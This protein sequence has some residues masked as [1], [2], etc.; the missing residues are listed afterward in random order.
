MFAKISSKIRSL[1]NRMLARQGDYKPSGAPGLWMANR[2]VPF[3]TLEWIERMRLDHQV[4]LCLAA[5]KGPL[6]SAKINVTSKDQ[7]VQKLVETT[8]RRFWEFSL[9]Q[10]TEAV[11][12][13]ISGGELVYR[14]SDD[15][16]AYD[17]LIDFYVSDI[18]PLKSGRNFAGVRADGV[19]GGSGDF[20]GAKAW[21]H[22]HRPAHGGFYGQSR[23]RGAFD[24]WYEKRMDGGAIDVRKLWFHKNAFWGGEIRFPDGNSVDENGRVVLNRDIARQIMELYRTGGIV[25]LPSTM[26]LNGG[27]YQW[28]IEKP[29]FNGNAGDILAYSKDLDKEI[30]EGMEVPPEVL[31]ASGTGAYAG[32]AVPQMGFYATLEEYLSALI[33][34]VRARICNPLIMVNYGKAIDYEVTNEPLLPPDPQQQQP[35]GG[36]LGGLMGMFGGGGQQPQQPDMTQQ[37]PQ[38]MSLRGKQ[39]ALSAEDP[40]DALLSVAL[41]LSAQRISEI[42]VRLQ[43]EMYPLI[44]QGL[45]H[46]ATAKAKA[47]ITEAE[48]ILANTMAESILSSLVLGLQDVAKRLPEQYLPPAT[49][50]EPFD[51][52]PILFPAE[53]DTESVRLPLVEQAAADLAN[54]RLLRKQDFEALSAMARR[55]AF[56]VAGQD[57]LA[58]I[59]R[60]RDL[61]E[62]I[63]ETGPTLKEFNARLDNI[64]V[65]G[66]APMNPFHRETIYRTNVQSAYSKGQDKMMENPVV[67]DA[68]PYVI[69]DSIKDARRTDLC[70]WF[71]TNGI[72]GTNIYRADD[73][74]Y[75][76]FATP[77]HYNCRTGRTFITAEEAA[78]RGVKEAAD[79]VAS[80]VPPREPFR[81]PLPPPELVAKS[82]YGH[83]ARMS[84]SFIGPRSGSE[85]TVS[86][87]EEVP[88]AVKKT[89]QFVENKPEK[90]QEVAPAKKR[91]ITLYRAADD[92]IVTDSASFSESLDAAKEYL[93]NPGFGGRSLWK[94]KVKVDPAKV[95]D[96][97]DEDDPTTALAEAVNERH[98]GAIG[99]DEWA[100][101]IASEI[102]DAGYEWVRV[103]ES[104]PVDSIT[105]IWVGGDDPEMEPHEED[106]DA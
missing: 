39:M 9:S 69:D 86:G 84:F 48:P 37:Q 36:G 100:P 62:H 42:R 92:D 46:D 15:G 89:G 52:T 80:G 21:W 59:G 24:P 49:E 81:M 66:D 12:Y 31:E 64:L 51:P 71:A 60:V 70:S 61:V 74:L 93:N 20:I 3:F 91:K 95:L 57:S 50:F 105:W 102:A 76:Q 101:R 43:E 27:G 104:H 30:C 77:R 103:K 32:R 58:T 98:P 16:I 65:E 25:A 54:R 75:R 4:V 90:K 87:M 56:T 29:G 1:A 55:D 99:A 22:V 38:A 63:V 68:F 18:K 19:K 8:F 13:G 10:A 96:L 33:Q 17:R 40:I 26:N 73:P 97:V 85:R 11:D 7:R 106:D 2:N 67:K 23:L 5:I 47:I 94:T 78:H 88:D 72:Q 34:D 44:Q 41:G 83:G 28:V 14:M 82:F 79:W 35:S 6:H 45:I 53:P